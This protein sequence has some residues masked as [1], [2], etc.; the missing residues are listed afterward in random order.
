[1]RPR[2]FAIGDPMTFTRAI[3]TQDPS[4][5]HAVGRGMHELGVWTALSRRFFRDKISEHAA[6]TLRNYL[7]GGFEMPRDTRINH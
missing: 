1:M 6:S 4:G 2:R 7:L 5:N 3:Q